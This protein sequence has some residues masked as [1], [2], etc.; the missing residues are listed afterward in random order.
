M[1]VPD[2]RPPLY[3]ANEIPLGM[4]TFKGI[5]DRPN[6]CLP[7]ETQAGALGII[8]LSGTG[9]SVLNK[10]IVF[11][12]FKKKRAG[13]I[14]DAQ[15]Q[16][17]RLNDR[18][19]TNPHPL[20]WSHGEKPVGIRNIIKYAPYF[21]K[22]EV[23]KEDK[24]FGFPLDKFDTSAFRSI[25][26][27]DKGARAFNR[28][29]KN[30]PNLT[31]QEILDSIGSIPT[32]DFEFE[33]AMTDEDFKLKLNIKMNRFVRDALESD[34]IDPIERFELFVAK[35]SKHYK[36]NFYKEFDE[37]KV[38]VV[39]FHEFRD[40][41]SLYGGELAKEV[42]EY[43]RSC[44]KGDINNIAPAVLIE[45]ADL[46]LPASDWRKKYSSTFWTLEI[47][48]R[49]RKY[50]TYLILSTQEASGLV[51]E[52]K[53]HLRQYLIG[54]TITAND[55]EYFRKIFPTYVTDA[56]EKLD[57]RKREWMIVY[58]KRN[59]DTFIPYMCPQ[60]IIHQRSV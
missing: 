17:H 30:N 26:L 53:Q 32:S 47:L 57:P 5:S 48:K 23:D 14:I 22:S 41:A 40:F 15:G 34:L 2:F 11:Y 33:K 54:P 19:N 37:K 55:H 52:V 45:E 36:K 6:I 49:A 50:G 8:G 43:S 12:I 35:D 4:N 39:S 21:T 42:Y 28:I 56:I 18:P 9:K 46:L 58:D 7:Y 20:C 24:L 13:L 3:F 25:N 51:A 31:P 27:T 16:D 1:Q 38:V 29:V 59:F 44:F 10:R 60:E